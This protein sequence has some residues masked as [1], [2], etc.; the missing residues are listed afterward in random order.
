MPVIDVVLDKI[1]AKRKMVSD[2]PQE[3]RVSNNSKINKIERSTVEGVG[4]AVLIHFEFTTNYYPDMGDIVIGGKLIYHDKKLKDMIKEEKGNLIFKDL[5]AFQEVQNII[6]R[7]STMEALLISK[8]IRLPPPI[9][10]PAITIGDKQKT[11]AGPEKG[12]A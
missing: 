5:A 6:L 1:E 4:D 12:Y 8:E 7:T 11:G 10:M 9:Q 3:V 2:K